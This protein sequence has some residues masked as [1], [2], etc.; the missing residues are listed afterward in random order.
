MNKK[1]LISGLTTVAVSLPLL[2][3]QPALAATQNK[4]SRARSTQIVYVLREQALEANSYESWRQ[5]ME[6]A[7]PLSL[8]LKKITPENFEKYKEAQNFLLQGQK[9]QA[10]KIMSE[11]KIL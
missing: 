6:Q 3:S 9:K 4:V 1:T 7:N 11:L 10:Q 8:L 2:T 5:I